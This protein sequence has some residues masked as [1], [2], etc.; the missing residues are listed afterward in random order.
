MSEAYLAEYETRAKVLDDEDYKKVEVNAVDVKEIQNTPLGVY[1]FW[2]RAML[3][4]SSVGRLIQEKDRLILM[5]LTDV[6][7]NLHTEGFGFDL[8]FAFEKNDYFTNEVLKKSFVMTR[9]NVIE[10]CD[11]TE[12]AWRDGKDV[13]K[14]KIKK[15]SKN[16]K[17]GGSKTVTKTVEQESFFNFFKTI[18]M[19]AEE[20]LANKTPGAEGDE[21]EKDVGELMD[22]DF[23]LGN[24]FKDQLIPLALEYYLEVI[25]E[26][27]E[28]G[29]DDSCCDGDDHNHHHGGPPKKGGDSDDEE[30]QPK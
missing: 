14:K 10:K 1:G 3:N 23:E 15:K 19:P 4:H 5:H 25:E 18:T 7:C 11:G 20:E 12:I 21:E 9:Q 27:D 16:K 26:E 28:E 8:L 29:D 22:I 17:A 24:E 13:T 2:L 6:Q 30:D